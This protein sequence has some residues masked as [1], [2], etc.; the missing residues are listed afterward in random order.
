MT[1]KPAALTS[2]MPTPVGSSEI[3]LNKTGY[4]NINYNHVSEQNIAVTPCDHNY[5]PLGFVKGQE[6]F[7]WLT[8]Y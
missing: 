2:R 6:L 4:N 1:E 7:G 3:Y 5:E 8:D